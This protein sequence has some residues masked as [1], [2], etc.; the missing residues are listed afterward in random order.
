MSR[1]RNEV[2]HLQ[3]HV[4]SLRL[5]AAA[6]FGAMMLCGLGWWHTP[7]DLT[8]H[9]PP[10]LRSGSVRKWW[11]VP[12]EDVY[13]FAL[14]VFEEINRWPSNGEVDYP[15][16]IYTLSPYLT[17]ECQRYLRQDATWRGEHNELRDRVRGVFEIPGRGYSHDPTRRVQV[18]SSD[19]WI[20]A[21]DLDVDE[22][23]RGD[24]VKRAF[25]R[26]PIRVVRYD[27]D[28]EH[29]PWG[30][31]LDCF[32]SPP[33]RIPTPTPSTSSKHGIAP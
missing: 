25:V 26:Y 12:P 31:A 16:N 22:Y 21:L 1:F 4:K 29:N 9:I 15:R 23:Y 20:V 6:L 3:A 18:L 27:V 8:I 14:Y 24:L 19:D 33:E 10:D 32:A 2:A 30:L 7:R 13:A 5:C 11:D 28:P 17:P